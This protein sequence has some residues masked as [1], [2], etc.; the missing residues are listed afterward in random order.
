MASSGI[1]AQDARGVKVADLTALRG[2]G[3]VQLSPDGARVAYAITRNDVGLRPTSEVWIRDLQ[4]GATTRLGANGK[5][6]VR[7]VLLT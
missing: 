4:T 6:L 5:S 3:E 2:L 7:A 1:A